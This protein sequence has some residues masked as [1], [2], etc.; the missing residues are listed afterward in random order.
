MGGRAPG[1]FRLGDWLFEPTLGQISCGKRTV[2]LRPRAVEVLSCLAASPGAV[3]SR[4]RLIDAVWRTSHVSENVVSQVIT[5]LRAAFGDDARSPC[6]IQNIPRRG[7]RLVAPVGRLDQDASVLDDLSLYILAAA[8]IQFA[9]VRG[10]N[11]VGRSSGADLRIN[12]TQ[13]SRLHARIVVRGRAATI[14]DLES[15]NGTFINGERIS[16]PTRL[17]I[18]D[19]I[20]FGPG[21]ASFRFVLA[22]EPTLPA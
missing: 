18:G 16:K 4:D 12:M 10:E 22:G 13:V 9:L 6:Y 7:Y 8:G 1:S 19:E 2:R 3:V 17:A 5:E 14:E 11:L 15:K 20:G 21:S